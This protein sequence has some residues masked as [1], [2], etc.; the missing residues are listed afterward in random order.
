MEDLSKTLTDKKITLSVAE[1]CTGGLLGS[2]LTSVPGSSVYFL[3]GAITYS[4]EL[5]EKLLGV[6]RLTLIR[7]G[8]VSEICALEMA[9]GARN[10][11]GSDISISITG[12]A[13]PGGGT[14][15]KPVGLVWMGIS[16][17]RRT[18]AKKYNFSGDRES[19][20]KQAADAAVRLLINSISIIF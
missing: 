11:F 3:G 4:N 20:R 2:I 17:E 16:A 8:A 12:I 18:F 13:G 15:T 9:S 1:S 10:A 19:I 5:K 14:E 7:H 6:D